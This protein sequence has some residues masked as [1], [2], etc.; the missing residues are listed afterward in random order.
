MRSVVISAPIGGW[1]Q[2]LARVH[3]PGGACAAR[4]Q[5]RRLSCASLRKS[6]RLM[7][8]FRYRFALASLS[9][10]GCVPATPDRGL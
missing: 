8:L 2:Y 5:Q 6:L 10:V 3:A 9:G 4:K 1:G 7:A